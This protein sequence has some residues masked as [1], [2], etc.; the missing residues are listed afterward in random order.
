[1]HAYYLY[2]QTRP[3]AD[4]PCNTFLDKL[5]KLAF[6]MSYVYLEIIFLHGT[7]WKGKTKSFF[8]DYKKNVQVR[9]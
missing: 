3:S 9:A 4:S 5:N 8:L 2:L 1:M 7:G 6:K